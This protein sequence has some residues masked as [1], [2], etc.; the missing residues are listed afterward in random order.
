MKEKIRYAIV[1]L[2]IL[3]LILP[4]SASS[5]PVQA[6]SLTTLTPGSPATIEQDLLINVVFVGFDPSWI[7]TNTFISWQLP[8]YSPVVRSRL[9][10]GVTEPLGL[11]FNFDYN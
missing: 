8:D 1:T 11:V 4:L 7:N 10:Y 2:I 9:W 3:T 5:F 6:N